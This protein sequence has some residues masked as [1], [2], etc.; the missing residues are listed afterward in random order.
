[1]DHLDD[2]TI[3]PLIPPSPPPEYEYGTIPSSTHLQS[4]INS[5]H[6]SAALADL[7]S[8]P[9]YRCCCC[10]V[11]TGAKMIVLYEFTA[12]AM[13]VTALVLA[14]VQKQISVEIWS[15]YWGILFIIECI[16]GT[17]ILGLLLYG[18]HFERRQ[19]LIP[20]M[21]V[22]LLSVVASLVILVALVQEHSFY[23]LV[24]LLWATGW[25]LFFIWHVKRCY[26]YLKMKQA[27]FAGR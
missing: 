6:I 17:T 4:A 10:H 1:M 11:L 15:S 26:S 12:M 9:K 19:Y 24:L 13:A 22:T 23:L 27:I 16:V 14:T 8:D 3:E 21:G 7:E 25:R 2:A 18:V 20:F 5:D